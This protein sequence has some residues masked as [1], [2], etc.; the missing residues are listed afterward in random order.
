MTIQLSH[1]PGLAN[2]TLKRFASILDILEADC[3]SDTRR[4]LG[5]LTLKTLREFHAAGID[6][7]PNEVLGAVM[8][9]PDMGSKSECA[10]FFERYVARR[11]SGR[12][13][14]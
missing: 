13:A 6:A 2:P 11:R 3:P 8:G 5:D 9:S 4:D 7:T 10:L 1:R 14:R 12:P